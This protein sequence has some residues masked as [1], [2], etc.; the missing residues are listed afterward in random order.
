VGRGRQA[1]G[2]NERSSRTSFERVSLL[3]A[4][5]FFDLTSW[6]WLESLNDK[7]HNILFNRHFLEQAPLNDD[8]NDEGEKTTMMII[9][10]TEQSTR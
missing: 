2:D 6:L 9:E 1:T 10:H 7:L 8:D 4:S 3:Y 5:S